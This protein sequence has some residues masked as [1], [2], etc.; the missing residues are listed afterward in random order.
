MESL[1]LIK[2]APSEITFEALILLV[3]NAR[4]R[5][6][7]AIMKDSFL[8]NSTRKEAAPEG[9]KPRKGSEKPENLNMGDV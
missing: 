4:K 2:P 8:V 3:A 1:K 9:K 6:D 7:E 5:A